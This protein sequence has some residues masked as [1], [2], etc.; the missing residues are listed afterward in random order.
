MIAAQTIVRRSDGAVLLG[1]RGDHKTHIAGLWEFPGGRVEP[2]ET[3][4]QAACREIREEVGLVL[5]SATLVEF[6]PMRLGGEESELVVFTAALPAGQTPALAD[7]RS[8]TELRWVDPT[9]VMDE[10]MT[11]DRPVLTDSSAFALR[12]YLKWRRR[13]SDV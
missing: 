9:A 12:S 4:T 2:D 10:H 3:Y 13:C 8:H 1:R 11:S 6:I 5:E 7:G